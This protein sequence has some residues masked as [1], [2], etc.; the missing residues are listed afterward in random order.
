MLELRN[1]SKSYGENEVLKSINF[2]ANKGDFIT[3][4]GK[5]GSGKSTLL[6][7]ISGI[8]RPSKGDVIINGFKNPKPNSSKMQRI[9]RDHINYM[10]QNFALIENDTVMGNLMLALTYSKKQNRKSSKILR[11]C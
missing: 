10:F 1:V 5:S 6:N 11:G 9:I 4:T 8:E 7:I 3:I 2:V